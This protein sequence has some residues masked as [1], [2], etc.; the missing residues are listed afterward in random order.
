LDAGLPAD[1]SLRLLGAHDAEGAEAAAAAIRR[2]ESLARAIEIGFEP[3]AHHLPPLAAAEKTGR[4]G[5]TL[6]QL[7]QD[8]DRSA[9]MRGEFAAR[10]AY[11]LIL[12]HLA[13][14]CGST[15]LLIEAPRQFWIRT[16]ASY[17]VIWLVF[18]SI[19]WLVWRARRSPEGVRRLLRVPLLGSSIRHGVVT[20]FLRTLTA[21]YGSGLRVDHAFTDALA[22]SG[23]A[24]AF[25]DL[26]AAARLVREQSPLERAFAAMSSLDP[27]DRLELATAAATGDLEP[28]LERV[29][30]RVEERWR[31]HTARLVRFSAR[32]VYVV[33]VAVVFCALLDFYLGY[34]GQI[35]K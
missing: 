26:V 17:A 6:R 4:V 28:A 16:F 9:A 23:S 19:G 29:S 27:P 34:V 7:A 15:R 13:V 25:P 8:L 1:Q 20:R 35:L 5:R 10:C 2:G 24:A 11:P 22:S 12:L 18:G 14:P 21:A 33:A 3:P 32:A 30:L 31:E